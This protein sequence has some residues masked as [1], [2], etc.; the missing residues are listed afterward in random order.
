MGLAL[1]RF[2]DMKRRTTFD[3]G[4]YYHITNRGVDGREIFLDANDYRRFQH[5]LYLTN[6][7]NSLVYRLL[8]GGDLYQ[9]EKGGDLAAIG[10]YALLPN[11]FRL[12]VRETQEGGIS[13]FLQ[14]LTTGYSMYFNNKVGRRGVLF[15]GVFRAERAQSP[16]E[17]RRFFAE[18]HLAPL[19]LISENWKENGVEDIALAEKHLIEYRPSSFADYAGRER[20][21]VVI[22]EKDAFL[23]VLGSATD[24]ATLLPL[25]KA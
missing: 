12:L 19:S 13:R 6:G 8:Q 22:L 14:K 20:D 1:V 3:I 2:Y 7:E 21:D 23:P 10:A 9:A 15:E 24:L 5:L 25:L 4:E 17:L 18:V 16:E 11:H